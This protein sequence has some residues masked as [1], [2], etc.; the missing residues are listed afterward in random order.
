M[1]AVFALSPAFLRTVFGT[2]P[3]REY[4]RA[5]R[6]DFRRHPPRRAHPC[7]LLDWSE[8]LKRLVPDARARVEQ[9]L[10]EVEGM[11]GR[12]GLAHL[13]GAGED[14]PPPPSG[15]PAGPPL[16]LW[17]F[18]RRPATFRAVSS[19]HEERAEPPW[20]VARIA[21]GTVRG[22]PLT[23]ALALAKALQA[24]VFPGA[25]AMRSCAIDVHR[26]GGSCLFSASLAGRV[27]W[28]EGFTASGQRRLQRHRTALPV[29]FALSPAD[30]TV[31]L[32]SPLRSAD[33][34]TGLLRRFA[35]AVLGVPVE[36]PREV[37]DLN[38][39]KFPFHP[40]PTVDG[41][42]LVRVKSVQLR[43]PSR[44]CGRRVTFD[45][46]ATDGPDAVHALLRAHDT[47]DMPLDELRVCYAEL[48]VRLP[49]DGEGNDHLVRLWPDRCGFP[50]SLLAYRLGACFRGWGLTH[51]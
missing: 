33:Q 2:A 15:I 5:R 9:E 27:R 30:G 41:I 40:L 36:I 7:G 24:F 46:L 6:I 48:Q 3:F 26:V 13:L 31:F 16:A 49:T 47:A 51:E 14:L 8:A 18:M 23:K 4:C 28:V 37:F 21:K 32:R 22:N 25:P 34:E 43:Y 19:H 20:R 50:D 39:L 29:H 17:F 44:L 12:D 11:S 35:D 45:T 38:R 42:H 1:T 10:S